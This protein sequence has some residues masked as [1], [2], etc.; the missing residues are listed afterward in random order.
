[1]LLHA[2]IF[3]DS[4][5][6]AE[7]EPAVN[8]LC[9]EDLGAACTRLIAKVLATGQLKPAHGEPENTMS[10]AESECTTFRKGELTF[11]ACQIST[12]SQNPTKKPLYLVCVTVIDPQKR[13]QWQRQGQFNEDQ[14]DDEDPAVEYDEETKLKFFDYQAALK[15]DLMSD[16][17]NMQTKSLSKSLTLKI[18]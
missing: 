10:D 14:D 12:S 13:N 11:H 9:E 3:K 17:N 18:Q 4:I 8:Y 1:M 5:S 16:P 2:Q 7:W 15:A 6:V